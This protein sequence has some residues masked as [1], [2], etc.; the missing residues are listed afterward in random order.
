MMFHLELGSCK[1]FQ[2][3]P[4]LNIREISVEYKIL[5]NIGEISGMCKI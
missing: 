5:Y 3:Y 2:R 1:S 4:S